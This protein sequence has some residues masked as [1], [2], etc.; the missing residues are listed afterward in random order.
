MSTP[1]IHDADFYGRHAWQGGP[2]QVPA[3]HLLAA[4]RAARREA[5]DLEALRVKL[6]QYGPTT[7]DTRE[8]P[9]VTR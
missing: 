3:R 7:D 1:T 5:A 9:A 8:L 2:S 6:A 4:L